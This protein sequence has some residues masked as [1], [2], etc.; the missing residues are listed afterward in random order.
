MD[1]KELFRTVLTNAGWYEGRSIKSEIENT[2]FYKMLPPKI[3]DFYCEFGDLTL[4]AE[5]KIETMKI[6]FKIFNNPEA[7]KYYNTEGYKIRR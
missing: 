7:I 1:K 2:P 5:N 3:Q 6:H 4:H